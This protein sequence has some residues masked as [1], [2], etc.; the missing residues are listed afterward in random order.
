MDA[1][2]TLDLWLAEEVTVRERMSN[3]I[4]Y[5]S[6]AELASRSG[7][8]FLDAILGGRLPAPPFGA[9][10]DV[11]PIKMERGV[12]IFQGKPQEK[13]YNPLGSVH[14]GWLSSLL[15]SALGCAIH[16]LLPAGKGY[17]TLELK[18]NMIRRLTRD[19]PLVRAT[20]RT[21]HVGSQVGIAEADI[22]G[23]D[24]KLFA[25]ATTTC[26]IFDIPSPG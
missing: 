26:L 5:S 6:V 15:D 14:G 4:A 8:E 20:G 11:L 22:K 21:I 18:V 9:L 16:T 17:T 10:I 2:Q 25:R 24:G 7:M 19:V 12:S 13:H 23:P 1:Q 3:T